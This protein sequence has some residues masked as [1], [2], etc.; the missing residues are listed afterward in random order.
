MLIDISGL[1]G[2]ICSRRKKHHH[3]NPL[4]KMK[5]KALKIGKCL[6]RPHIICLLNKITI[7]QKYETFHIT[8]NYFQTQGINAGPVT[9]DC[10]SASLKK[11]TQIQNIY[12]LLLSL[13]ILQSIK[14][15][16]EKWPF[17]P[18]LSI[19][20]CSCRLFMNKQFAFFHIITL[21][22]VFA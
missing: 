13:T 20:S 21:R 4:L 19:W 6:Q 12:K 10:V 2:H 14:R 7:N 15:F 11:D 18:S 1:E 16:K 5:P 9:R 8:G 22:L 3:H 17:F